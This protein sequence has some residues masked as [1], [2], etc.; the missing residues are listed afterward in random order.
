MSPLEWAI[1][2]QAIYFFGIHFVEVDG[3]SIGQ[4]QMDDLNNDPIDFLT[5]SILGRVIN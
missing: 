3:K 4:R 5:F 1:L 2:L